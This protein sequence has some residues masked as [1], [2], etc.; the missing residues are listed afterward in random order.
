MAFETSTDLARRLSKASIKKLWDVYSEVDWPEALDADCWA[1]S[2]EL[3]SLYGTP[4]W[5][6]LDEAQRRRLALFEIANFFSLTLQGERPL[7][8]GLCNQMYSRQNREVTDYIHH[9]L[10]EENKHMVLFAEFCNRYAGKVYPMKKLV[11]P[12]KYAKGEEDVTFFIKA[13]IV[14]EL[15]DYYNVLIAKDERVDPTV[16]RVNAI[17]HSDEARHIIF[18]RQLLRE[19]WNEYSP[20]WEPEV[21]DDLRTW[22]ADY[23]RS[24]WADFYNPSAYRDAEVPD[25]YA[26]RKAA[27]ANPVCQEHRVR[28]SRKLIDYFLDTGIMAAETPL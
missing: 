19:L 27:L 13:L 6:A 26:A 21:L 25:A 12:K 28:A 18:G 14:E 23:L 2:P 17:H 24:S 7:V 3:I 15:G 10:D 5:D 9:F 20:K 16:R 22:L 4:T 8:Q 1:M 11:L